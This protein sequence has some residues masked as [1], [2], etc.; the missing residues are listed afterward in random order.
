MSQLGK[1]LLM[2]MDDS[3]GKIVGF[4]AF[5]KD[6]RDTAFT[7]A[8][9]KGA[10]LNK[11]V[12]NAKNVVKCPSDKYSMYAAGSFAFSYTV[13][14]WVTWYYPHDGLPQDSHRA[15]ENYIDGVYAP[16]GFPSSYFKRPSRTVVFVDQLTDKREMKLDSDTINDQIFIWTDLTT[17]RHSNKANVVFL[18]GHVKTIRGG[19]SFDSGR[20]PD[21]TFI[22]HDNDE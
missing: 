9:W 13:N 16:D 14:A 10:A 19:I 11:Y 12:K 5:S 4:N 2:Y 18:D 17:C 8:G 1:A 22:F 20:W 7:G 3:C 21:G 15:L 6:W